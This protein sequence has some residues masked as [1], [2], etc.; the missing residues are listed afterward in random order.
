VATAY[1]LTAHNVQDWVAERLA[2]PRVPQ[3]ELVHKQDLLRPGDFVLSRM[4][5]RGPVPIMVVSPDEPPTVASESILVLRP[6]RPLRPGEAF[7]YLRYI[8]S[9]QLIGACLARTGSSSSR[10]QA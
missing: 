7:F 8:R 3:H 2:L 1:V 9:D 10:R 6:R 4:W 5:D